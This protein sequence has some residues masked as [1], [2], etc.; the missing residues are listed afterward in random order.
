MWGRLV[1]IKNREI[2]SG[3][4][5]FIIAD[6]GINHGG[7]LEVAKHM[8]KCIA[9][10][11][12][13]C[14]KHQTHFVEDEMTEEAKSI[15][16]PNS[17][18]SIWDV[19]KNSALSEEDEVEL[20]GYAESLGLIYLSTPFSRKAVDFL[21]KIDIPAFKIGSGEIDNLPL[22]RHIADIGKPIILSTGMQSLETIE[23][24]I[25]ILEHSNIDF[26]LLECTNLYPS[27]PEVV[28][29]QGLLELKKKYQFVEVGFS[30]H[31]IG[32]TM[33]LGAVA[34]GA[35]II[36]RHFTDS[37][38]RIGP[39][40]SCSMDPAELRFLLDRSKEL[41]VALSNKKERTSSEEAVYKFA[42]SSVV[43]D[44][45]I[46]KG[47]VISEKDI[48]ARRPGNGEIPGYD[49]DKVIGKITKNI[50]KKNEQI[51]WNMFED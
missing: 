44:R 12:G 50:I 27:P 7:S 5:P 18:E 39:D 14:V 45:Q 19:I 47:T 2:G 8:V 17:S 25:N 24:A 51:R 40:I 29:L 10:S 4:S 26:A 6:I 13:E 9:D 37:R 43:A 22:V 20:K 46:P 34:L 3:N 36:E 49:Y 38:Y 11:G 28:S 32:P 42:R 1:K 41:H 21:N 48:W 15:Y 23:P 31:S 33:A 35:T 16:P 30:D